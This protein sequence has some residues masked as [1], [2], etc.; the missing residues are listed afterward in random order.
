MGIVEPVFE[1]DSLYFGDI[2]FAVIP[3]IGFDNLKNRL[4]RGRGYY[5]K[6]LSAK[7]CLKAGIAFSAQRADKLPSEPHD[8]PLDLVITEEGVLR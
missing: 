1:M 6:F 7:K 2:D 3:L 8:V 5:D 4:G